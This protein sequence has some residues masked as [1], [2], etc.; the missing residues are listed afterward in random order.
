MKPL[1]C[2]Y[3]LD[4]FLYAVTSHAMMFSYLSRASHKLNNKKKKRHQMFSSDS[5]LSLGGVIIVTVPA[6]RLGDLRGGQAE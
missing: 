1:R 5:C 4:P 6:Q 2:F 3:C